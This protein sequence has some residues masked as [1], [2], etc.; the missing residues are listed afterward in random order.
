M[1]FAYGNLTAKHGGEMVQLTA[2]EKCDVVLG[3]AGRIEVTGIERGGTKAMQASCV[4]EPGGVAIAERSI[5]LKV[6]HAYPPG[7]GPP[8]K[9]VVFSFWNEE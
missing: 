7:G 8:V 9:N 4:L 1:K 5:S 3:K 6:E 2:F